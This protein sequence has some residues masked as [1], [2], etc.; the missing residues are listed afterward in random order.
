M[1]PQGYPDKTLDELDTDEANID[2]EESDIEEEIAERQ[3]SITIIAGVVAL[4]MMLQDNIITLRE[5]IRYSEYL[6]ERNREL[7]HGILP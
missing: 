6:E 3:E 4:D 5:Y 7:E 2:V 1:N